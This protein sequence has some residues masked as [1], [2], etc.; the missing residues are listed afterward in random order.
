M[1]ADEKEQ[2]K[3]LS[4]EISSYPYFYHYK[5]ISHK[6]VEGQKKE[7]EPCTVSYFTKYRPGCL[8]YATGEAGKW[9]NRELGCGSVSRLFSLASER[10][11]YH[12]LK[13]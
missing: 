5:Q 10:I 4:K 3:D 2:L 1:L 9:I 12:L 6:P 13:D 11:T 7:K 8:S